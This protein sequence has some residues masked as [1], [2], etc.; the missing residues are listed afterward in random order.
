MKVLLVDD[1]NKALALLKT[2]LLENCP[3]VTQILMADTLKNGVQLIREH[4]PDLV[5]LDIEMP[6]HSGL[7]ILEFF[8]DEEIGFQIIFC[9][10]Y[11]EYAVE[12]F[13]L[14]AVDYLLKPVDIE[15]LKDAVDKA[16]SAQS[17]KN[18]GENLRQLKD[19]FKILSK[20]KLALEVPRG[21]I[22]VDYNEVLYFE[23]DGMYTYVF[24]KDKKK[25]CI[26]K[27]LKYFVDQLNDNDIFYRPHRSYLINIEAISEFVKKDGG[28]LIM[29]DKKEIAISR[30][31]K[32]SF[33]K[34][35]TSL[36][37]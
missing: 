14:S 6:E 18:I 26:A 21:V 23:A 11:N 32:D 9:T 29:N 5:F 7:E 20:R 27:P 8:K 25:E 24:L 10:A 1:E 22:F 3:Q 16:V 33:F 19:S 36:I 12:A 28:F 37:K 13:K 31:K 34:L 15:E 35:M 4:K 2:L 30:D 17:Q